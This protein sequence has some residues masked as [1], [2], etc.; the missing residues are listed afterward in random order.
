MAGH[1]TAMSHGKLIDLTPVAKR[2]AEIQHPFTPEQ[3]A[4]RHGVLFS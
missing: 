2:V 4:L 3:T 1:G